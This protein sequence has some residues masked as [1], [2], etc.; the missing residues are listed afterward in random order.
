[1]LLFSLAGHLKSAAQS[2]SLALFG[3]F[4]LHS[5]H[6]HVLTVSLTHTLP[7][8][9]PR[10]LRL[11]SRSPFRRQFFPSRP[12]CVCASISRVTLHTTC[13][14]RPPSSPPRVASTSLQ[15]PPCPALGPCQLKT[16]KHPFTSCRKNRRVRLGRAARTLGVDHGN[17]SA[18]QLL[19]PSSP[20]S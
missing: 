16:I 5:K 10:R 8:A 6:T 7:Q 15:Q 4:W 12:S 14:T 20:I 13:T 1:M 2:R 9:P 3:S 18:E 17:R 11:E 19:R